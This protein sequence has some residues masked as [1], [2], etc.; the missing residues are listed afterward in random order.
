MTC[1]S[2]RPSRSRKR[3]TR[4]GV[5][6]FMCSRICCSTTFGTPRRQKRSAAPAIIASHD[7]GEVPHRLV[8]DRADALSPLLRKHVPGRDCRLVLRAD[9]RR[10]GRQAASCH[11]GLSV[12]CLNSKVMS[13]LHSVNSLTCGCTLPPSRPVPP[14]TQAAC[15]PSSPFVENEHLYEFCTN[16]TIH[17]QCMLDSVT[18]TKIINTVLR[19]GSDSP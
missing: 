10:E 7:R 19:P 9:V 6:F 12:S 14:N 8:E 5:T 2:I 17:C 13:K 1:S 18:F 4:T 11:K 15:N 3:R 16:K